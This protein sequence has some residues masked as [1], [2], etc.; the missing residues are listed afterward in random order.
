[1]RHLFFTDPH[2]PFHDK[3]AMQCVFAGIE[4]LQPDKVICGGDLLENQSSSH[5]H[6]KRRK[7]PPLE[8]QLKEIDAELRKAR[9]GLD[10]LDAAIPE[11]TIKILCEGNHDKRL[12]YLVEENPFLEDK[13][14]FLAAS[15]VESRGWQVVPFGKIAGIDGM[16]YY[17]GSHVQ[18]MHHA[19]NHLVRF[20]VDVMYG[21]RHDIQVSSLQHATGTITAYCMGTLKDISHEKNKWLDNRPHRWSQ[22]FATVDFIGKDKLVTIFPIVNGK[23]VIGG[24]VIKG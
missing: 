20:G 8:Y 13:Y 16:H 21:D 14:S 18:N 17:H 12:D 11:G 10:E 19:R 4:I 24:K 7:R 15:G 22:G 23:T 3:K 9:K 6:Y 2:Y 1:M 5:W